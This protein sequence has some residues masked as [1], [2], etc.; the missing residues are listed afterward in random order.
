MI[1]V[2]VSR[3]RHQAPMHAVLC[4]YDI[5]AA[6]QYGRGRW[7]TKDDVWVIEE[8]MR[9]DPDRI[10]K[11]GRIFVRGDTK[12]N[13]VELTDFRRLFGGIT[14]ERNSDEE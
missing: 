5:G 4:R 10:E 11:N 2:L 3:W 6:D 7:I 9:L 14:A 1:R 13:H 8:F 12:F